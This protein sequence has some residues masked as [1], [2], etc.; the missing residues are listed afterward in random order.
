V[1][2]I[3]LFANQLLEEAKRF[4][5]KAKE[6]SDA[7]AEAAHLH[8]ALM[9]SFCSLEAHVN[10][11]ADEFSVRLD[12][13]AHER[14]LMLERDVGLEDGEFRV[15]T[16]LRMARLEDRIEF[17]HAKFSG[18]PVDRSLPWWGQLSAATNLR[19]HLT[20]AKSVPAINQGA[21]KSAIQATIDALGA[22][23]QAIYKRKFPLTGQG[24]QS[25]LTF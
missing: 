25:R 21:V 13:S 12:L 4:F 3:D 18:K 1:A 2:E 23:Y 15:K 17:L 22:L 5:E 9:L 6:C 19:N 14:G 16:G 8:A 11:I 24:L 10:S 7:A 20:H